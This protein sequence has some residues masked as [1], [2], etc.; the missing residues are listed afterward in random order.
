M[1]YEKLTNLIMVTIFVIVAA[2]GIV[3]IVCDIK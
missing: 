2:A 1:N 3:S